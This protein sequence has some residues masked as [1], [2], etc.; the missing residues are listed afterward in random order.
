AAKTP[1][2]EA[3]SP[4][5]TATPL[6]SSTPDPASQPTAGRTPTAVTTSSAASQPPPGNAMPPCSTDSTGWPS[7]RPTP[8]AEDQGP[9]RHAAP[10]ARPPRQRGG[11][12]FQHGDLAAL[13]G[14][15]GGQF[16]ADPAGPDHGQLERGPQRRAQRRGVVEGTQDPLRARSGQP[17]RRGSGGHH[18]RV[19]PGFRLV[20]AEDTGP[21]AV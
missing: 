16:G 12:R 3:R 20:R 2:T 14:G 13:L 1:G 17:H 5:S 4:S 8:A 18:E 10:A 15:A 21:Q 6:S 7:R 19:A 11:R 9:G